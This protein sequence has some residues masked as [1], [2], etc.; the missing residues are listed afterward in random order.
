MLKFWDSLHISGTATN[1][2]F[3][4]WFITIA[5]GSWEDTRSIERISCSNT[6]F[7]SASAKIYRSFARKTAFVMQN[8]RKLGI[9]GV[10]W[11]VFDETAKRHIL[12]WFHAFWAIDR[13]NP[14]TGFCSRR[15]HEKKNTTKSHRE[16]IFY[17]FAGNSPPS[18]IQSKLA[19]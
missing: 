7:V 9:L 14:F 19:T 4:C 10:G 3:A 16:V 1:A 18:Q 5:L 11:K 15:V 12:A 13:A 8:F 17:V 6:N 2:K